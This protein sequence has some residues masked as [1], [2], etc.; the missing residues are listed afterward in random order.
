MAKKRKHASGCM[1]RKLGHWRQHQ[2]TACVVKIIHEW[3]FSKEPCTVN[4]SGQWMPPFS[5]AY[6]GRHIPRWLAHY[7]LCRVHCMVGHSG[8]LHFGQ[9]RKSKWLNSRLT[10]RICH[11]FYPPDTNDIFFFLSQIQ[12]FN[13]VLMK[14]GPTCNKLF[15]MP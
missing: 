3:A 4:F 2:A 13:G 1:P 7:T 5:G 11:T 15:N 12:P 9:L 14:A 10:Q 6:T 8:V